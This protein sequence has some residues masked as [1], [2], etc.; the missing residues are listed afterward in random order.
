MDLVNEIRRL[1]SELVQGEHSPRIAAQIKRYYMMYSQEKSKEGKLSVEA[2]RELSELLLS[3]YDKLKQYESINETLELMAQNYKM[4][5]EGK[6]PTTEERK[7]T[8]DRI[9]EIHSKILGNPGSDSEGMS[10][11]Y[12]ERIIRDKITGEE[13]INR[14]D[15]LNLL[16][17][18]GKNMYLDIDEYQRLIKDTV[19]LIVDLRISN[20]NI[21]PLENPRI[22]KI[23]SDLAKSYRAQ[24]KPEESIAIYEKALQLTELQDS[25]EYQEIKEEYEKTKEYLDTVQN[26]FTFESVR[27]FEELR[28]LIAKHMKVTILPEEIFSKENEGDGEHK[29]Q[30]SP[31]PAPNPTDIMSAD[32]KLK[33]I[34]Q[35]LI[36]LQRENPA[37]KITEVGMGRDEYESYIILPLEGTHVSLM[38]NFRTERNEALYIIKNE[39]LDKIVTLKKSQVRDLDTVETANH[40]KTGNYVANLIRKT[41]KIMNMTGTPIQEGQEE[42]INL[43][44]SGAITS[45]QTQPAVE[46]TPKDELVL[47]SSLSLDE[48]ES[49]LSGLV[50][51]AEQVAGE[52]K[53]LAQEIKA[54]EEARKKEELIKTI[55]E[56]AATLE[57]LKKQQ[58]ALEAQ[59][60]ET[61]KTGDAVPE[62]DEPEEN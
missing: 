20:I 60:R 11:A 21:M 12:I 34:Q 24:N 30:P 31:G 61:K 19:G 53:R 29:P 27:S 52:N 43:P 2:V 28:Q 4:L 32:E 33:A 37:I 40:V 25:V 45:K 38:E 50:A 54:K 58:A 7:K 36:A 55:R 49:I 41:K 22:L 15:I 3:N 59:L 62:G 1:V 18:Q 5:E 46:V 16:E 48:L 13:G 17:Q 51:E 56:Q 57:A 35:M 23:L 6:E 47:D 39:E 42:G 14:D 8:D 10:A 9:F 44:T 26:K